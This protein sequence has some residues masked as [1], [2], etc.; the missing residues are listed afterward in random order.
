[1]QQEFGNYIRSCDECQR[2]G[3]RP[4]YNSNLLTPM[5]SLLDFVL[6]EFAGP[7]PP[8]KS[9]SHILLVYV[10][11]V[12]RWMLAVATKRSTSQEVIS[13]VTR[14][15]SNRLGLPLLICKTHLTVRE[16]FVNVQVALHFQLTK[17]IIS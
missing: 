8:S 1:M 6:V 9:G 13:V 14:E 16:P 17:L 3:P 2:L 10:E 11:Y 12:T 7:R 15:I 5:S 4:R